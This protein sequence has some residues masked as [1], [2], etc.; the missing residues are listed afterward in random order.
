MSFIQ[1]KTTNLDVVTINNV[2]Y[3]PPMTGGITSLTGDG[4]AI[5]PGPAVLT[6]STVNSNVGTF[7]DSTHIP[8][9]TTNAKGLITAVSNVSVPSSNAITALTGDVTGTGPGSTA[10]TLKTVNSDVGTFG[11]ADNSAAI[12]V[13][14]KGLITAAVNV[15]TLAITALTGDVSASGPGN[16]TATL[17]TVNS[18]VGTFGDNTHVAQITVNAKGLITAAS[19]VAITG[20]GG[21]ITALTGDVT[22]SG[23]GSVMATL[24]TVNS[25]TGSFGNAKNS[26]Q[27]TVNAKGLITACTN[28]PIT[29]FGFIGVYVSKSVGSDITGTGS[30]SDPY[31]SFTYAITQMGTPAVNTTIFCLDSETYVENIVINVPNINIYAPYAKLIPST[32]DAIT[33]TYNAPLSFEFATVAAGSITDNAVNITTYGNVFLKCNECYGNL[34]TA[35]GAISIN[36]ALQAADMIVTASG[37][38]GGFL[39]TSFFGSKTG[40]VTVLKSDGTLF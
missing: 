18:D 11:D 20:G 35:D 28:I 32:G 29:A 3:P 34:R 21:G 15:P 2:P 27:L 26:A 7:G 4:T 13:N 10:T 22:A 31:A 36:I 17:S 25:N 39:I 9:I 24:A 23:T 12:T 33:L 1:A 40:A 14:A 8:Q 38:I 19:S 30:L 16:A 5:G 37:F 6:L